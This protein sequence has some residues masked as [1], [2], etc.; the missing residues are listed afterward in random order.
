[1]KRFRRLLARFGPTEPR[2]Y[3]PPNISAELDLI[4]RGLSKAAGNEMRMLE[5]ASGLS[6]SQPH[7][8]PFD[9]EPDGSIVRI[10]QQEQT[11]TF[12]RPIP[13]VKYT[14]LVSGYLRWLERK[15]TLPG[16]CEVETGDHVIDCGAYIGGFGL[17]VA[18]TAG[19]VAFFE[20]DPDNYACLSRNI[21]GQNTLAAH[22]MGLHSSSGILRFNRSES[23][24]EHSFLSPDDGTHLET[25]DVEIVR[26]DEFAQSRGISEVDFLKIEA[27]GVEIEVFE[28]AGELPVRKMAIDVSDERD[29]QSPRGYFEDAL[30][31]R[32]YE[33]SVRRNVL[34]ARRVGT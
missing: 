8:T 7:F 34:F 30:R 4:R 5:F 18:G 9:Y 19:H 1:M 10:R 13:R 16:F 32:G 11:L 6:S 15:Y 23:S 20:P 22:R 3:F 27:E 31:R 21:E 29:G 28:G 14:L 17:S 26:L 25:I 24:V 12:P 33:V 2:A